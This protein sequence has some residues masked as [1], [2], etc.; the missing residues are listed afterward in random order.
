MLGLEADLLMPHRAIHGEERLELDGCKSEKIAVLDA[1]P[2][3]TPHGAY[4]VPRQLP[5]ETRKQA[6]IKQDAHW[7]SGRCRRRPVQPVPATA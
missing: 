5:R 1:R 3:H 2:S 6:F 7:R 4:F